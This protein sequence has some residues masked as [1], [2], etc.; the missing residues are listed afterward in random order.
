MFWSLFIQ[1]LIF[2]VVIVTAGQ[3]ISKLIT[4][5]NQGGSS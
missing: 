4:S 1:T 2:I 3:L 5:K